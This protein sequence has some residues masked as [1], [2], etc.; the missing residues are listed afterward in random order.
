MTLTE[1]YA[2]S[3]L[4]KVPGSELR[5]GVS[6]D[7]LSVTVT[8]TLDR[9]DSFAFTL[10]ER[11]TEEGRLFAGGKQLKWTDNDQLKEGGEVEIE[12]GY[13]GDLNFSLLGEITA[14]SVNFP[15]SG[16]PTVR[17][18]GS[19]L[20]HHL[21]R[22]TRRKPF[23]AATDSEIAEEI[24]ADMGFT[25]ETDATDAEH[26]LYSPQGKNYSE[27][28]QER[29]KRIGYE[30][31]VKGRTLCFRKP[32]YIANKSPTLTL[33][34]G[35]SLRSFSP[36]LTTHDM[37]TE[38]TV[39]ATQTSQGNGKT[40]LVG[41]AKS[42]EERAR[43]GEKTASEIAL[44]LFGENIVLVDDHDVVSSQEADE[45][46][47]AHLEAHSLGFITGRGSC[48]GM[49]ALKAR[50]VV[51]LVGLGKRFSGTY[52]VTSTTHTIDGSGY[53]TDFEVK[54]NGI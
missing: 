3:F 32:N 39:R 26:P 15:E 44:E 16:Q 1:Q 10:R 38:V 49:P 6:S 28:L 31:V 13:V 36:R 30:A 25:A 42:G 17:V 33:E 54:R 7:V 48:V 24:A 8:D 20:H 22:K 11:S 45:V 37:V 21:Q 46:A 29:A 23:E 53:R 19:S 2:P 41:K 35:S 14:V 4:I 50:T 34:W 27:I 52:Y 9:A 18:E 51:E 5:H 40:P 12:L 43:M 47:I